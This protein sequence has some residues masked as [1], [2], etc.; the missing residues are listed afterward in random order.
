MK[1]NPMKNQLQG[2]NVI[3]TGAGRGIGQGIAI[4][5][6]ERGANIVVSDVNIDAAEA[7]VKSIKNNGG[8]AISLEADVTNKESMN[9]LVI[10]S[11]KEFGRIEICVPNAGVIGASGFVDRTNYND[12]DWALTFDINVLGLVRTVEAITPHMKEMGGG[13]IVNIASH[14]GRVPRGMPEI[15]KGNMQMPYSVSKAGAI[16]LTHLMAVEL[17]QYNINVNVVCPGTLW[18][19]MWEKIASNLKK[20]N[21]TLNHLTPREIFDHNIRTR[22]PLGR[23][24]TPEDIG[25]TVA[26]LASDD[27]SE[28]TGQAIN[29]N[30]GAVMS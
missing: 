19:P 12:E 14:G 21:P 1:T 17:G 28:I 26:F 24:Q 25:K 22:M 6:A 5:L 16:Q 4:I 20:Q 3:V 15:G 7:V 8:K 27:A 13:K 9:D 10:N 29:V 30:G 11:V 23:E 2:K 18:T